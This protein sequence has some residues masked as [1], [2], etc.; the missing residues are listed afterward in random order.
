MN[1]S[2]LYYETTKSKPQRITVKSSEISQ[3]SLSA[4][5]SLSHGIFLFGLENAPFRMTSREVSPN[6]RLL[7]NKKKFIFEILHSLTQ[8]SHAVNKIR[9]L[10]LCK[11][12]E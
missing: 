5:S 11:I 10:T 2:F 7:L 6:S 1:L 8:S 4:E 12:F 3:P 9:F